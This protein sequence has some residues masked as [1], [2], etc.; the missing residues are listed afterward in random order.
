MLVRFLYDEMTF[1][2]EKISKRRKVSMKGWLIAGVDIRILRPDLEANFHKEVLKQ[3]KMYVIS[4][5]EYVVLEGGPGLYACPRYIK[6]GA[7]IFGP[8]YKNCSHWKQVEF[9]IFLRERPFDIENFLKSLDFKLF[10]CLH[11]IKLLRG[12]SHITFALS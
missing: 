8:C 2:R 1:H 6:K 9:F 3:R 12:L 7:S 11:I 5:A 4:C 10:L